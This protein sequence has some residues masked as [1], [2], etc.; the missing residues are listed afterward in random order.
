LPIVGKSETVSFLISQNENARTLIGVQEKRIADLESELTL[1]KENS[2]SISKSYEAAKIEISS[3][4]TSNEALARAVQINE[5]TIA[6]LQEDNLKQRDKAKQ[7]NKG[8]WKAIAVAAG[9]IALK[10]IIP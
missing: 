3:L 7:A 5:T 8:K 9:V 6:L 4:K 2:D 10:F 1:E